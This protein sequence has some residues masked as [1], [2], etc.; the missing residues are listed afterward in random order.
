MLE[1]Q[2]EPL[3]L[4][5]K[6]TLAENWEIRNKSV[7]GLLTLITQY[8]N[9]SPTTIQEA[10]SANFFRMLK[11]PL[12]DLVSD[13]RSIQ[14][15]D[16]CLFLVKL[17]EVTKDNIN[18]KAMLREVFSFI[19]D[20]IKV[21]NRVMSGYVDTAIISMIKHTTFK[22]C[23]P[24]LITEIKNSKAKLV[25]EHCLVSNFSYLIH[26]LLLLLSSFCRSFFSG[27]DEW[28]TPV[29][30]SLLSLV[31]CLYHRNISMRFSFIGKSMKK[32]QI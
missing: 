23:L 15:R 21:P 31:M 13:L 16:T 28:M 29:S 9:A 11:E 32:M 7:L 12:K 19:L 3:C 30:A 17:A 14:I 25:R 6:Q 8:E 24:S 26:S 22:T 1:K 2:A 4:S 20:G 27:I 5:I 10:F 18:M